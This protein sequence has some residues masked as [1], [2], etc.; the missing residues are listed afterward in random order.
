MKTVTFFFTFLI[1]IFF[2]TNLF[3][4]IPNNDFENWSGGNPV[5]WYTDNFASFTPITQSSDH[6]SGSSAVKLTIIDAGAGTP[7]VPLL[8]SGQGVYGFPVSEKYGSLTGYYKFSPTTGN[9]FFY[10]GIL[11][12]KNEQGIG[13]GF[14]ETFNAVSS[15]TQFTVPITYS[16]SS[17]TPDTVYMFFEVYDSTG[18]SSSIGSYALVD[19][20]SFGPVTTVQPENNVV[21]NFALNQNYP[22]PF[23]P[24]TKIS[25]TIPKESFI[26]LKVYNILGMEVAT[27]VDRRESPG[28]YTINFNAENLPSGIY[29]AQLNTGSYSKT[30]KMTLLK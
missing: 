24:T 10:I 17:G 27:L 6:Q 29:L 20:I 13:A 16:P 28:S 11:M 9:T 19:N 23:N 7:Y 30:I 3:A 2:S 18:S 12:S 5:S 25:Y 22:N 14:F 15:Y 21:T 26:S 4:Q 8:A 1:A